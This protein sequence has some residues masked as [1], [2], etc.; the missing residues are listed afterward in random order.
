MLLWPA[1]VQLPDGLQIR[2]GSWLGMRSK[3]EFGDFVRRTKT[4][5]MDWSKTH[6]KKNTIIFHGLYSFWTATQVTFTTNV[7]YRT[8]HTT[9]YAIICKD[10]CIELSLTTGKCSAL[11]SPHHAHVP[12][13]GL[14]SHDLFE[15]MLDITFFRIRNLNNW[16]RFRHLSHVVC[17]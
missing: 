17:K 4:F 14:G 10:W 1:D 3:N 11:P 6:G 12:S 5:R 8:W 13:T 2:L 15:G 16:F 9:R 7:Y